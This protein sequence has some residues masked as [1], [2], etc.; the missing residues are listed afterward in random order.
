MTALPFLLLWPA[1]WLPGNTLARILDCYLRL[2]LLI[3]KYTA[4]ITY[5]LEGRENLP[6]GA[7]LIASQHE[8]S[9]ETIYFNILLDRPAMF[10]KKEIFSYPLVGP[11]TRKMGHIP[12]DKNGSGDAMRDGFRQGQAIIKQGRKLLIFPSGT[13]RISEAAN[14]QAGVGVIYQLCRVPV[15]PVL[16]NSGKCW[17]YGSLLKYPG[18]IH[19]RILPPLPANLERGEFMRL[20]S[21]ELSQPA[22]K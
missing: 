22:V 19:V 5:Q 13:R 18:T 10:A 2:Q 15:V 4:G 21:S 9:W 16:L 3:L 8:S 1:V 14:L 20:L 11:L 17:P 6:R 12:V 7:F